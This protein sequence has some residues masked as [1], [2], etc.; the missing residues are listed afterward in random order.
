[1][2]RIP[3]CSLL[4]I[5]GCNAIFGLNDNAKIAETDAP[6]FPDGPLP[7]FKLRYLLADTAVIPP[8]IFNEPVPLTT[9]GIADVT[10]TRVGALDGE[11]FPAPYDP[12]TGD[13]GV[14]LPA[15]LDAPWRFRYT[16]DG[17]E[18]ELQWQP[19]I[20]DAKASEPM[21]GRQGATPPLADSGY[22]I[23]P[24]GGG[25]PAIGT[26]NQSRVFT[27][28]VFLDI[29]T[30]TSPSS[31][32]VDGTANKTFLGE[33]GTPESSRGDNAVLVNYAAPSGMC[34]PTVNGYAQ[35]RPPG[36]LAGTKVPISPAPTWTLSNSKT[37]AVAYANRGAVPLSIRIAAAL[38]DDNGGRSSMIASGIEHGLTVSTGLPGTVVER[39]VTIGGST[40]AVPG[41]HM[42]M[43]AQ[44]QITVT[45]FNA[46]LLPFEFKKFPRVTHGIVSD[47]RTIDGVE[48]VSSL[49]SVD[50]LGTDNVSTVDLRA[51]LAV[52]PITLT[53]IDSTAANLSSGTD[54]TAT[55][56]VATPLAL[57]FGRESDQG[58]LVSAVDYFEIT[59]FQIANTTLTKKRVFVS[60]NV[61][62]D[63]LVVPH[64]LDKPIPLDLSG[65]TAG[66]Y[67]M[68]IRAVAGAPGAAI[69]DYETVSYPYSAASVFTRTF[70]VL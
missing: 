40:F 19:A 23:Q 68:R 15:L 38:A 26:Y 37:F 58:D 29:R 24:T 30:G 8:E 62:A 32:Q 63:A 7:T 20:D 35:F 61:A 66:T 48:L 54:G 50:D 31:T 60:T 16:L 49:I 39:P 67:V 65:L 42:L 25:T 56:S 18:H 13:V 41:P 46:F 22:N 2:R 6:L 12:E 69:G 28:G 21:I 64:L 52:S 10:R 11:L 47:R 45:N 70:V 1:M 4:A 59:V 27:T 34:G 51:P 44:C 3:A 9:I 17:A 43:L 53:A 57:Q 14:P 36:L 5:A 33:L 55:I